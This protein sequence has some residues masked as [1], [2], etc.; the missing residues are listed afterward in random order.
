MLRVD[1]AWALQTDCAQVFSPE[2][3]E[4]FYCPHQSLGEKFF[5]TTNLVCTLALYASKPC[6]SFN[7]LSPFIFV[8]ERS[9][10]TNFIACDWVDGKACHLSVSFFFCLIEWFLSR[11]MSLKEKTMQVF[12]TDICHL[13]DRQMLIYTPFFAYDM[14]TFFMNVIINIHN[15][16][17]CNSF[18]VWYPSVRVI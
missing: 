13:H 14:S 4:D 6:D 1:W 2:A 18:F 8:A 16:I 9:M 5:L 17:F 7:N 12:Y 3:G 10:L 15:F 11:L